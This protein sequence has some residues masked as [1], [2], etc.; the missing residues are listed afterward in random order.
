MLERI[1]GPMKELL[2]KPMSKM[3]FYSSMYNLLTTVTSEFC[4]VPNGE[5]RSNYPPENDVR[6]AYEEIE[7][8]IVR[9]MILSEAKR[10]D[11]RAPTEIRP[12]WCEI[13]LSPRA[14]GSGLFTRG[15]T[16]VLS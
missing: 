2:R 7:Q 9:E 14:H 5:D 4:T 6:S 11:G 15:E 8:S 12:I 16:Q 13:G 3:E 10:P 1:S